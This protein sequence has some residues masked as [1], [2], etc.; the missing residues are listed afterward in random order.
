MTMLLA[1]GRLNNEGEKKEFVQ[2]DFNGTLNSDNDVLSTIDVRYETVLLICA[3][4]SACQCK[5][6]HLDC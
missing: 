6:E 4:K 5:S 1:K 2:S 3:G